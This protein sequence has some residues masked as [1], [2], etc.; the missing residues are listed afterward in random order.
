MPKKSVG[1][2]ER[3]DY[4]PVRALIDSHE[5]LRYASAV[6]N[7]FG[8]AKHGVSEQLPNYL[9]KVMETQFSG[10]LPTSR[11]A[12]LAGLF[13][14]LHE[15]RLLPGQFKTSETMNRN[16]PRVVETF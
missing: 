7:A 10:R 12:D 14:S 1:S 8:T 2:S 6:P 11:T 9:G 3:L 16:N 4:S 13:D 15:A 5:L